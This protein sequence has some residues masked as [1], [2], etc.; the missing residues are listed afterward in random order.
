MVQRRGHYWLFPPDRARERASI[1]RFPATLGRCPAQGCDG[2]RAITAIGASRS[3]SIVTRPGSWPMTRQF[4]PQVPWA[5]KEGFGGDRPGGWGMPVESQGGVV[6]CGKIA[7]RPGRGLQG[8]VGPPPVQRR[9]HCLKARLGIKRARLRTPR[10]VRHGWCK[11]ASRA[12]PGGPGGVEHCVSAA[13]CPPL[14]PG[15][16]CRIPDWPLVRGC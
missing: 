5:S 14:G 16:R 15:R 12:R 10:A 7:V 3:G 4:R 6:G 11:C 1:R 9:G 8:V 13:G 2:C